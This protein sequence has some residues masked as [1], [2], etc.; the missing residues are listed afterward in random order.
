MVARRRNDSA[1]RSAGQAMRR[2]RNWQSLAALPTPHRQWVYPHRS[3]DWWINC[4]WSSWDDEEWLGNFRMTRRTF[5]RITRSV[6]PLMEHENTNMWPSLPVEMRVGMAIWYLAN[7][8]CFRTVKQ[9]FG[10]GYTSVADAVHD[11]CRAVGEVLFKR[12]VRFAD[13]IDQVMAGFSRLG[14]PQCVGAIDGCHIRIMNPSDTSA[15]MNRKNVASV[16]LMAVCDSKGRFFSANIGQPGRNHDGF[17]FRECN[18]TSAMDRGAFLE[19]NPTQTIQGVDVPTI[20]IADGAFPM[21]KWLLKPYS[22]A[23]NTLER[24]FN[25]RLSK[26]RCVIEQAFGRLKS[27][28]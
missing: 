20:V 6:A 13:P 19:S 15:Y 28:W 18:F 7:E 2:K 17:A 12:V 9:Q 11:F 27:R 22:P 26:A 8:K 25:R 4:V 10:T 21:R 5:C 16:L 24:N 1:Q 23:H 3:R 14:F